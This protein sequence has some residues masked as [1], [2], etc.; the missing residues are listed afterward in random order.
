MDQD[1]FWERVARVRRLVD[2]SY[3]LLPVH[4]KCERYAVCL[5]QELQAFDPAELESF[6]D[7]LQ[8]AVAE[9]YTCGLYAA[10]YLVNG[11]GSLDGFYSFRAWLVFQGRMAHRRAIAEP[12]SLA[13]VCVIRG[14]VADYEYED[15]LNVAKALYEE[16]AGTLMEWRSDPAT[17]AKTRPANP[18]PRRTFLSSC[19]DWPEFTSSIE[20][21][22][23]CD[24]A[25]PPCPQ[26]YSSDRVEPQLTLGPG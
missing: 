15:V 11:G 9:A 1:E 2:G 3:P 6:Q 19:L 22:P 21:R 12:D 20:T 14:F 4:Q 7:C 13:D 25:K 10:S 17:S 26:A 18:G 5:R 24:V 8:A 23:S 16:K